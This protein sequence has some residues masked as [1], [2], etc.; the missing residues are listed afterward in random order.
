MA[1]SD[2][3][4]CSDDCKFSFSEVKLG[5]LPGTISQFVIP[6]IGAGHARSLFATGEIFGAEKALRIGLVHEVVGEDSLD[7]MV[8]AKVGSVLASG[9]LA[10]A[11]AKRLVHESPLSMEES[12]RRLA[13]ARASDEGKEGV[14]AFLDKRKASWVP[15]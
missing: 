7:A 9:P 11:A 13:A 14:A 2:V 4:V 12:A 1:A 10:V 6:K 3:A 15:E 5:L 8:D